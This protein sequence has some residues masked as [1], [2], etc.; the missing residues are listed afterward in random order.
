MEKTI[1]VLLIEDVATDARLIIH[2]LHKANLDVVSERVDSEEALEEARARFTPDVILSDYSLPHFGG[3][4]ALEV[5][6]QRCPDTPFIFVSGTIGEER[7]IEGLKRGAVD[8][9]LKDKRA[10]LGP[11]ALRALQEAEERDARRCA[12][13]RL[14]ESEQRFRL[15]MDCLPGA[16]FVKDLQGR[17][18]YVN[19]EAARIMGKTSEEIIGHSVADFY[20]PRFADSY[21]A[22]DRLA[23]ETARDVEA[24][25]EGPMGDGVHYFLTHKFPILDATRRVAM[26]GGISIDITERIRAEQGQR[27]SE[28]RFRSIAEAIQEWIWEV[29]LSTVH[30]FSNP[31]IE[32]ILGYTVEEMIGTRILDY[33]HEEEQPRVI[34]LF[35]RSMADKQGWRDLV[36][37]WRHKDGSVRWME[38]NALPLLGPNGTLVGY[39]GAN[40]DITE[41]VQQHEKIARLSRIQAMLSGINSTIVRVRDRQ[42][43]FREACRIAVEH[44]KFRMAWIGLAEAGA[45]KAR[46]VAWMG[47][48]E[49]YLDEIGLSL[50]DITEDHGAAGQAL[51]SK[52]AVVANDVENDPHIVFKRE[53]LA[54]GYRSLVALP[55]LLEGEAIGVTLLYAAEPDFFDQEELTLLKE[56]AGDISFALDHIAKEERLT[57]VSYYDTLTGLANRQL[58]FD[59]LSQMLNTADGKERRLGVVM[60]DLQ[61]FRNIND[62]FGRSAGDKVLQEFAGRLRETFSESATLARTGGDRFAVAIGGIHGAELA[63][64]IL[65]WITQLQLEPFAIDDSDI[66]VAVKIGIALFPADGSNADTLFKNAEAALQRAK[67]TTDAYV[68]YSPE[69]NARVAERLQ[70]ESRLRNALEKKQ[71]LLHYQPKVNLRTRRIE[72]LEALIRWHDPERGLV[73]PLEFIPTLEQTGMIVDVGRW[74]IE[75]AV[76]DRRQWAAQRLDPPRIAVNVS[77][78]QLRQRDFVAA[79]FGAL[80]VAANEAAGVDLE[81]TESLIMEDTEASIQKMRELRTAGV[82]IF[83][84]DFGTGYSSLSQ[85]A[86]LPLDA[87][88]IDRAF[89]AGMAENAEAMVIVSTIITLA[90]ALKID[91]VAEGVK[92]EEQRG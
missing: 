87:L 73:S 81:I 38:S 7:A 68:F 89:I 1:K 61:R 85:L 56:L 76:A 10:R 34:Q 49:G 77:Q 72:G 42:E 9:V 54:R 39:R 24:I 43:L 18:S 71:L 19:Q 11:A 66:R 92:T 4:R 20:P 16:A 6:R 29:N 44:G 41:R 88:K 15:F 28:E 52:G 3:L 74:V 22:N 5:V 65:R 46:P 75:Q 37:R 12:E 60:V 40:R 80:G 2:N 32:A 25:E 36:A 23:V 21:T 35:Q 50:R 84:D 27:A 31:A 90:H 86:K 51:R 82:Q 83:M 55:L 33:V 79:V 17:F 14:E 8:Y 91:V 58:F 69:M 45:K 57:Y 64:L 63:L 13:H 62:S 78:V 67:D 70:L 30:T 48:E 59:R 26:I 53:A 47:F